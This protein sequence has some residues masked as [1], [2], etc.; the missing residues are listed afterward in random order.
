MSH[1]GEQ[2]RFCASRD[3]ARIAYAMAGSGPPLV[4]AMRWV[5]HLK[6]D[7]DSPIWRAWL[8]LLGSRYTVARYDCRG[9]GLSDREGIEFSFDAFVDDLEAV[10]DATRLQ[11]FSLFGLGDGAARAIAYAVKYPERVTRLVLLGSS[12]RGRLLDPQYVEE[13][14]TRL[15]AIKLAWQ[16]NNAAFTHN[17]PLPDASVE[18]LRAYAEM[19]RAATSP[20]NAARVVEVIYKTDVRKLAPRVRCPTLVFHARGDAIHP[21][22]EGRNVAALIP[23]AHFVPLESRNHI[24]LDT[25]PAWRQFVEAL[26]DFLPAWPA[27]TGQALGGLTA[28]ECEVLELVARGHD[29]GTIAGQLGISEKTVRNQVSS[30]FS[31]LRVNNRAQAVARARD[32]GFG[33]KGY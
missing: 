3:G 19:R 27:K 22:D 24:L 1:R 10:I 31:K 7:W 15:K 21:F 17:T 8:E 4:W 29:N 5:H 14:Q 25:E 9:C 12:S 30:I 13:G 11:Q 28:R 2:I 6:L 23:K 16:G 32:T 18:Q 20:E 33:Q 26:D